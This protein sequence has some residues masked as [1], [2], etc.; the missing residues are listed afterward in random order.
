[1]NPDPRDKTRK[2]GLRPRFLPRPVSR[3][4]AFAKSRHHF[5]PSFL[6]FFSLSVFFLRPLFSAALSISLY[7]RF[8][9]L[10]PLWDL[11]VTPA[12]FPP[13]QRFQDNRERPRII[14][15]ANQSRIEFRDFPFSAEPSR[16]RGSEEHAKRRSEIDREQSKEALAGSFRRRTES[17]FPESLLA[18][19]GE[20]RITERRRMRNE[21]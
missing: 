5:P 14:A 1:M 16:A 8:L 6:F 13:R 17:S 15:R 11:D 21:I 19:H 20:E 10:Q 18:F 12:G 2:A 7:I 9:V 4:R 3:G